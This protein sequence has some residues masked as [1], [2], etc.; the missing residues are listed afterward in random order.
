MLLALPLSGCTTPVQPPKDDDVVPPPPKTGCGSTDPV[1]SLTWNNPIAVFQTSEGSFKAEVFQEQAP[2]TA[3]N[4]LNL[5]RSGFYNATLFHRVVKGFVIQGGDPLSKDAEPGND[6]TGGA[7]TTIPD[8]FHPDLLHTSEGVL[9]MANSGPDT[10]SSQFFITLGATPHLDHKHSVFGRICQ[11]IEAVRKIGNLT[12]DGETGRPKKPPVMTISVNYPSP[13]E[14]YSIVRKL[15]LRPYLTEPVRGGINL[16]N[17]S[18]ANESSLRYCS[19]PDATNLTLCPRELRWP[20]AVKNTGNVRT[21]AN[22]SLRMPAGFIVSI[23]EDNAGEP[24][25][26]PLAEI[27]N[28]TGFEVEVPAGQVKTF[29]FR[30][31]PDLS[32]VTTGFY[33]GVVG[34]SAREEPSIGATVGL[35]F[36]VAG[37]GDVIDDRSRVAMDYLIYLPNGLLVDTSVEAAAKDPSIPKYAQAFELR[38][39]YTAILL[40]L[41]GRTG[42]PRIFAPIAGYIGGFR[43]NETA[44]YQLDAIDAYGIF[45]PQRPEVLQGLKVAFVVMI[46]EKVPVAGS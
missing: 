42:V 34:V 38:E 11:G 29:I 24:G 41:D 20:I 10:G 12:T 26:P 30:A 16:M 25:P 39:N 43:V 35:P 3:S 18:G 33:T 8:E 46:R 21:V 6:G 45:K 13:P 17:A 5:A 9:S 22:V 37:L 28:V 27:T 7:Q 2:I 4:F 44:V 15:S 19:V 36:H 14:D 1:A 32:N 31:F 23:V 40:N